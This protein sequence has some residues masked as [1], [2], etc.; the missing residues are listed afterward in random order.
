MLDPKWFFYAGFIL[1]VAGAAMIAA[2]QLFT[3]G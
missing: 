3:F 2:A 1:A